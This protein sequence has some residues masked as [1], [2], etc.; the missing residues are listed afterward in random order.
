LVGNSG[1]VRGGGDYYSTLSNCTIVGNSA[2]YASGGMGSTF[3]NCIVYHNGLENW[4]N[5]HLE[6]CSTPRSTLWYGNITNAPLFVNEAAGDFHLQPNS[7]CINAGK[8]GY[9]P[10]A[11]D[12]DGNPRVQGGT[13]DIGAFEFQ[14]PASV[15]SYAWLQKYGLL[16]NGSADFIDTDG[17]HMNNWQEWRAGTDPTNPLSFLQ[18]LRPVVAASGVTLTWQSGAGINYFLQCSTNLSTQ[19][20][21]AFQ[22]DIIGSVGTTTFTDSTAT[23]V[24]QPYFYRVG[25]Q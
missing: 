11:V 22:T 15:I 3:Y 16:T 12:F 5:S 25:V 8:N 23:N 18:L 19:P 17:D 1:G 4:L 7:P 24:S 6:F 10:S 14:A 2:P 13:V 21:T 20:L 9:A